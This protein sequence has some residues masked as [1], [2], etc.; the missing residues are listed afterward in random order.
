MRI[1][2]R[3]QKTLAGAPER[4]QHHDWDSAWKLPQ[5]IFLFIRTPATAVMILA[6][7]VIVGGMLLGKVHILGGRGVVRTPQQVATSELYVLRTALEL[8]RRD[9]GRYP[10]REEGLPALVRNPG[11][12]TWK[13]PYITLLKPDPWRTWYHYELVQQRVVLFSHGPDRLPRTAD[14]ITAPFITIDDAS[15]SST[16]RQL[17]LPG[18]ESIHGEHPREW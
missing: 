3:F 11:V 17:P 15:T 14:D 8:F 10:S 13:G 9:C 6:A 4:G 1:P 16:P 5:P 12:S 18:P 2:Q 7:M